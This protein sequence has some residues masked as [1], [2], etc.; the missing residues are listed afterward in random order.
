MPLF[1]V[2]MMVEIVQRISDTLRGDDRTSD[3]RFR[4]KLPCIRTCSIQKNQK[5]NKNS[6]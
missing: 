6:A 5:N 2:L 1:F 3:D 4:T